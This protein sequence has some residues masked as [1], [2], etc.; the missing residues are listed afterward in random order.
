MVIPSE[1]LYYHIT[2]VEGLELIVVEVVFVKNDYQ[3]FEQNMLLV[4][5]Y[6]RFL[7]ELGVKCF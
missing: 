1:I 2:W 4:F 7:I 6:G 3:N 5:F